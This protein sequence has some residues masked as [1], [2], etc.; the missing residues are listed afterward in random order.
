MNPISAPNRLAL[1]Q[2]LL[3]FGVLTCAK[4][5]GFIP[6]QDERIMAGRAAVCEAVAMNSAELVSQE[7]TRQLELTLS[8]VVERSPGMLSAGVRKRSGKLIAQAADH[9]SL[10]KPLAE[11]RSNDVQVQVPIWIGQQQWGQVEYRFEPLAY[12]GK[13]A[14]LLNPWLLHTVF[15]LA[16]S[17]V[18]F[19]LYNGKKIETLVSH[20]DSSRTSVGGAINIRSNS[21]RSNSSI[22]SVGV[23]LSR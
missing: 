21:I 9:N 19:T 5:L 20:S 1:G 3:L 13:H 22:E 12:T 23:G 14:W 2:V 18:A 6:D 8:R 17:Y 11:G 7:K 10:W 15:V 16:A 4:L